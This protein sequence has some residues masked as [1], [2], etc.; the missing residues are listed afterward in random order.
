VCEFVPVGRWSSAPGESGPGMAR[1][2]Y[3]GFGFTALPDCRLWEVWKLT[4]RLQLFVRLLVPQN[5]SVRR[6]KN[7]P[8]WDCEGGCEQILVFRRRR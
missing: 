6:L 5:L 4:G 7:V 8:F 3:R 1:E 2:V